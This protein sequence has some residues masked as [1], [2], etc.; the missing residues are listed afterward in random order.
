MSLEQLQKITGI[1]IDIEDIFR[2]QE[3]YGEL[4]EEIDT[5]RKPDDERAKKESLSRLIENR[6][7]K[8]AFRLAEEYKLKKE[9]DIKKMFYEIIQGIFDY[10]WSLVE[11]KWK[12]TQEEIHVLHT[13][14]FPKWLWGTTINQRWEKF[15][16]L[17]PAGQFRKERD[18]KK[19]WDEIYNYIDYNLIPESIENINLFLN[20][21]SDLHFLIKI[22][23]YLEYS[24]FVH[25]YYNGNGTA[26]LLVISILLIKN[27]Y[28]LPG[29][30]GEG[31]EKLVKDG[32][33]READQWNHE[34]LIR[35]F[36]E[37]FT[38][39]TTQKDT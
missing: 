33:F 27:W 24:W 38:H 18:F 15:K 31:I 26:Y 2:L 39:E 36:L 13:K 25:P 29:N 35:G 7:Y 21:E 4:I 10:S 5:R 16:K 12:I 8:Y 30:F 32:V 22:I 6:M 23:L 20:I 9:E 37:L 19:Y 14:L 1:N 11:W 17:Y 34:P 28:I 3:K